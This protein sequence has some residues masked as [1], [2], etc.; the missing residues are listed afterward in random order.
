VPAWPAPE[1]NMGV[2]ASIVG[3]VLLVLIHEA[4]HFFGARAVGMTPRKFYLG[5]GPPV[6]KRTRGLV[7]YGV[8]ALPLGGYVKIPGMN[9]PSPGDL[10][11]LLDGEQAMQHASELEAVDAA[12]E[13]ED[14]QDARR[15]VAQLRPQL[16]D[17]RGLD[18][19]A[20]SLE[21][22]AYW[23]QA[24]WR[25]L[26]AIGAGPGVNL[27]F[28][29]VLF[30][31]LFLVATFHATTF[32]DS[33]QQGSPARAAGIRH[34]DHV[35]A[36]AGRRVDGKNVVDAIRGSRGAPIRVTVVRD[37]RRV[38]LGPLSA[39]RQQDGIYRIGVVFQERLGPGQSLPAALGSSFGLVWDVTAGTVTGLADTFSGANTHETSST[40][41]IVRVSSQAWRAGLRE[42]LE[43][44]GLI[45]LALG[46]F[47]LLP[48]LPLDGGYITIAL[49][50]KVRGR[51][52]PQSVYIRYAVAGLMLI[53]VV[54]YFGLRNDLFGG[55]G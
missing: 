34:G 15:L 12:V 29:I 19:Y 6:L 47:N 30:T 27:V 22:D 9:R 23:R 52:F 21:P 51:T 39:R 46:V 43:I 17:V 38:V 26:V 32:V 25:R 1:R 44:L 36:V 35:V 8:G 16:G 33:T 53:A 48:V 18:E 3:L 54:F 28:A 50:E 55:G 37:G 4:G 7:E 10:R 20:W 5:F 11:R 45:S 49:I 13:R 41:G 42:F 14:W 24:T 31:T 40:V 2:V